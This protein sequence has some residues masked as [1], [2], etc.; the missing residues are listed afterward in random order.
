MEDRY[1][2]TVLGDTWDS[3]AYKLFNDS[4]LYN[5]LMDKNPEYHGV[6]IFEA[7]TILKYNSIVK[8]DNDV[9]PWRKE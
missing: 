4:K 7:G 6:L 8:N 3:I 1:Y 5:I 2:V 9:P